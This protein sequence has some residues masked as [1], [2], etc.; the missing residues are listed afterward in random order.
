[1]VRSNTKM[2]YGPKNYTLIGLNKETCGPID[3]PLY[4]CLLCDKLVTNLRYTLSLAIILH[5][6]GY[7]GRRL[8]GH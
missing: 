5:Y 2:A 4:I 8:I 7:S 6:I 1:M 3:Q